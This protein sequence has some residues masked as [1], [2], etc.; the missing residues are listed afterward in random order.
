[1]ANRAGYGLS[2]RLR[3]WLDV[4]SIMRLKSV[5]ESAAQMTQY[6]CNFLTAENRIGSH[7]QI[8]AGSDAEAIVKS[9]AHCAEQ[10]HIWQGFELWRGRHCVY[11]DPKANAKR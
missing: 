6:R 10:R 7:R 9:R 11:A 1:M 5:S 4:G 8:E 2:R 3:N